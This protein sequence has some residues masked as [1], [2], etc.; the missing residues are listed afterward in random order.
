MCVC[1]YVHMYRIRIYACI[2]RE[3]EYIHALAQ[4]MVLRTYLD[5]YVHVTT[6]L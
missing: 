5:E 6:N 2:C 4:Q 1:V 3:Y